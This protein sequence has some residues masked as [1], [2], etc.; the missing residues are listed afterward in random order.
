MVRSRNRDSNAPSGPASG[1]L[2]ELKREGFRRLAVIALAVAAQF[3]LLGLFI[4]YLRLNA[5]YLYLFVEALALVQVLVLLNQKGNNTYTVAWI[6][7]FLVLPI[8]GELLY[9]MW[10]Q[11]GRRSRKG[12]RLRAIF[13]RRSQWL[14]RD[15]AAMA[16]LSGQFPDQQRIP[17][18]LASLDFPIFA[19][20]RSR[21]YPLGELQFADLLQD[22]EAAE[23]FIFLEYYI[24]S[25][26]KLWASIHDILKR[27]AAA[28]VEVRLM[29]DDVGS[30]FSAPDRLKEMLRQEG[31]QAIAFGEVEK[32]LWHLYL[33]HR[34]HQKIAVIDGLIGY[35]GGTNLADEYANIYPKHGHWKDT[36]VRL[37]GDAVWSLTVTF[38]EMWEGESQRPEDYAR[39]RPQKAVPGDGFYVPFSDGPVNNP[40][41][42]AE[43][44]YR[45]M[46]AQ[47]RRYCYITTPYIVIDDSMLNELC[48]AARGGVDVRIAA[49]RIWDHWYV[50]KV[51]RSNYRRL[52]KAGVRVY[53]YTPGFMHAKTIISD[54]THAVV[55][56]I[57]MDFRS[58]YLHFEN[59]VWICGA[60]ILEQI[61]ADVLTTYA[62]CEE[63]TV[64]KLN[65]QPW[66]ERLLQT[67]LRL[68]SP[69][70]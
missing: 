16:S 66:R 30:M 67:F 34:N 32:N 45:Q 44:V 43:M 38:L 19:G 6:V 68:F 26:G 50:H 70:F 65:R 36:A 47:A 23:R 2:H 15:P 18:Y 64:D 41:N 55:G 40:E 59:G 58:F 35:T 10:G 11:S 22:L 14:G 9:L 25:E 20:T 53:E 5:V 8:F 29:Y 3:A 57:N 12:R 69:L 48:L 21:Y 54:D 62:L 17:A 51:T 61:V 52:I 4:A 27:K 49:P 37:E 33:N 1:R 13:S 24:V 39:Y 31:I 7:V 42:P 28:G 46:I 56:S 60:P 63:Y